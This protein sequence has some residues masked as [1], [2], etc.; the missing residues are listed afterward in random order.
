MYLGKAETQWSYLI[1]T[2]YSRTN[3]LTPGT[4]NIWIAQVIFIPMCSP[5]TRKHIL[6]EDTF[7]LTKYLSNHYNFIDTCIVSYPASNTLFL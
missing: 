5:G 7:V 4:N 2:T 3:P 6:V 1:Q